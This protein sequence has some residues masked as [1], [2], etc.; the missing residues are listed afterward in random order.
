[1]NKK[2]ALVVTTLLLSVALAGCGGG[3]A[4][5]APAS[6]QKAIPVQVAKVTKGSIK[7]ST[8]IIGSFAPKETAQ[9]SPKISGKIQSIN[10][11]VGQ[12]VSK[13]DTLFTIDQ[14][15]IQDSIKQS[16][17]S[18][19]VALANLKQAESGA[20]QSVQ[21]SES[22]VDQAKSALVQQDNSITQ[23]QT[24]L[25]DAQNSVRDAQNTLNRNQQL[26]SAGALSQSE[27]EQSQI[28]YRK[29]QTAV[30]NAQIALHNAQTSKESAQTTYNN[31]QKSLRL[32]QQ[33]TG[34]DVARASVNQAKANLDTA[35]SQLVDAVVKAPISGT[36]SVVTGV[37]GQMVS[38]QSAVVTIANTNPIIAKVNVSES[39]L[40][41]MQVGSSVT[42]GVDSLDKRIEARVSA[43]NPVMDNDL[44][45]YPVEISVP[46]GSGELKS[47][48]VV[49]VYMKTEAPKNI[50]VSQDAITE[51]A[52]KKYAYVVEGT[53]A[54]RVEVQ[55]GQESAKQVE[56]TK[57]LTEGQNVVVKGVSLLSDGAKINVVK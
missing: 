46:N 12:K 38:A 29:A 5:A 9:V 11:T 18:Y 2:S 48:M 23:A 51:Q 45:A 27:L 30:E 47:G 19:Q 31:A 15:D 13:G 25:V 4:P 16:Q 50:L 56:I 24:S 6:V 36:I 8:G 44:K 57:G 53:I 17:E 43:V 39:E 49:T 33:K 40:L 42:V 37:Q 54:K 26:F 35:R 20:E 22:S 55:T 52:G 34:I 28:T 21:Q 7:D 3:E 1:M 32:A 41:K 14:K 10:L